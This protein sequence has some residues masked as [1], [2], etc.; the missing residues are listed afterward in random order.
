MKRR[1]VS[2]ELREAALKLGKKIRELR[3]KKKLTQTTFGEIIGI[4]QTTIST[5]E[6]GASIPDVFEIFRIAE[7]FEVDVQEF[8][9]ALTL[10]RS[11]PAET[12]STVEMETRIQ[13]LENII[14]QIAEKVGVNSG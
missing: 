6:T 11:K 10:K 14:Y 9:P 8:K 3:V 1:R 2:P 13:S 4:P 7:L 12:E 5:W